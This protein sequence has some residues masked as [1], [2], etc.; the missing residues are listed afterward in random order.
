[1]ML[2]SRARALADVVLIA[3]ILAVSFLPAVGTREV[4]YAAAGNAMRIIAAVYAGIVLLNTQTDVLSG[5]GRNV[6]DV[7]FVLLLGGM[8]WSEQFPAGL[9]VRETAIYIF[10]AAAVS[11][12]SLLSATRRVR[13]AARA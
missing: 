2:S 8:A 10:A 1:M 11:L 12:L 7:L 13:R 6:L 9:H 3:G 4:H 5:F